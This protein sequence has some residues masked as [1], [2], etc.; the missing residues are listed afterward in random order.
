MHAFGTL[1]KM[2]DG[3]TPETFATIAEVTTIGGPTLGMDVIEVT[4]HESPNGFKEKI[5]ALKDGGEVTLDINYQPATATHGY[6][7]GL[8]YAYYNKTRKNFKLVFPDTAVTTWI[9]PAL[10]TRI[11]PTA[12]VNGKLGASVTLTVCGAPTLA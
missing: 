7:S 9:L 2:G 8:L 4:H 5:G 6:S 3:A 12:P 10:V 1:L 11:Q